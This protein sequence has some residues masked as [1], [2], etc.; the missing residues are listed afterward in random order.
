MEALPEVYLVKVPCRFG[1]TRTIG[2]AFPHDDGRGFNV[3]LDAL[4]LGNALELVLLECHAPTW[5]P[6]DVGT[7][8]EAALEQ[9]KRLRD[10]K[11]RR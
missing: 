9:K 2:N 4:P 8:I 5:P 11:S 6:A 3:F 7:N 10:R 1:G